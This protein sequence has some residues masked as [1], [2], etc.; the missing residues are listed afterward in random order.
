MK[1]VERYN[2]FYIY[3]KSKSVWG[4]WEVFGQSGYSKRGGL[5]CCIKNKCWQKDDTKASEPNPVTTF[6]SQPHKQASAQG[7][8]N[9]RNKKKKLKLWP[10][11]GCEAKVVAE[12]CTYP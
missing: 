5:S 3:I 7:H 8:N 6:C 9:N 11:A 10:A 1:L 4:I 12:L 2:C